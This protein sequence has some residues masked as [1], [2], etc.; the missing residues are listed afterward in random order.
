VVN[1]G[2]ELVEIGSF[3][4]LSLK[5]ERIMWGILKRPENYL[6]FFRNFGGIRI[7]TKLSAIE[8]GSYPPVRIIL[9]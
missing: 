3:L 1:H 4:I 5:K 2:G 8:K 7:E 9:I 6:K